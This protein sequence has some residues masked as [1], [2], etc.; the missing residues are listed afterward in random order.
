MS[1]ILVTGAAKG[2]GRQIA[3]E[4]AKRK[5]AVVIH[6]RFNEKEALK[7]VK[8]CR[9]QGGEAEMLQGDFE[10]REGVD[11]FI[12][13]YCNKFLETRGIVNNVGNYLIKPLSITQESEWLSLFQTNVNTPFFLIRSLLPSLKKHRG[14]IVNIG[15]V[16]LLGASAKTVA[17]AYAISKMAL[18]QL[19][20][21]LAQ[22]VAPDFVRV[23]MVSPGFL[24]TAVDLKNPQDLPMKRPASLPETAQLVARLFDEESTYI[25]GQNIEIAGGF[26]L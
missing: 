26:G 12:Q 9:E 1:W 14:H 10:T 24:E 13:I 20:R 17:P 11:T 3:I 8:M 15:T 25:T 6:Y 16:G 22:E 4:L 5:A 7:T 2:L 23:N 19:T 21:S 18:W